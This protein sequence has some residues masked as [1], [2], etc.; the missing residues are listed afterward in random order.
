MPIDFQSHGPGLFLVYF[1]LSSDHMF[2]P[3]NLVNTQ[4]TMVGN[5]YFTYIDA[6]GEGPIN[7]K[8]VE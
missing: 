2:N 3:E 4:W 7:P 6:D 1:C 8:G 5:N